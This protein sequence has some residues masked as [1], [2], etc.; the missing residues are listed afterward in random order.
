MRAS[1]A[2]YKEV[3]KAPGALRLLLAS[4]PSRTAYGMI[5]LVIVNSIPLIGGSIGVVLW[6]GLIVQW[7]FFRK[8]SPF[9]TKL[10]S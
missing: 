9:Y 10:V 8:S 3:V 4:L 6:L 2:T 5:S 7:I 1:L